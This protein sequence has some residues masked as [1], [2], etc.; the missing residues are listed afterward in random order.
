MTGQQAVVRMSQLEGRT[1]LKNQDDDTFCA[2][3]CPV[4]AIAIGGGNVQQ[5]LS[6]CSLQ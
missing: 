6:C 2:R 1:G 4:I 3:A 5:E